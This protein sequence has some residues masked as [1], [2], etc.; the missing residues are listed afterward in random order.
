MSLLK[1]I[2]AIV[3]EPGTPVAKASAIWLH[4]VGGDEAHY[5]TALYFFEKQVT[6]GF[7]NSPG[8]RFQN[9]LLRSRSGDNAAKREAI[10]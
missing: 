2:E 3:C 6:K 5:Q 8:E 9:L 7:Y 1:Q 10:Y 4:T